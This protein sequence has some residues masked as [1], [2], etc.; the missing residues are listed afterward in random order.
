[1]DALRGTDERYSPNKQEFLQKAGEVAQE[2]ENSI[3]Y[4]EKQ[5]LLVQLSK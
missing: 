5:I 2:R 1:M 3:G 4:R